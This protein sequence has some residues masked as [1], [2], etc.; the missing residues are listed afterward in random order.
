LAS[1]SASLIENLNGFEPFFCHIVN[2]YGRREAESCGLSDRAAGARVRRTGKAEAYRCYAGLVEIAVPVICDGEHIAT[3]L[4]GQVLPEPPSA[5]GFSQIRQS[6]AHLTYMDWRKL[7]EAYWQTP[8]AEPEDIERTMRVLEVFAEHLATN[9]KRLSNA[10][11]DEQ[12]KSAEMQLCR[13]EFAHMVFDGTGGDPAM[14]RELMTRTGFDRYPNRVLVVRLEL[15]QEYHTPASPF[16]L[17]L[18]RVLHAVEELCAG[19]PN[20]T[21]AYLRDR[22]ICV[23]LSDYEERNGR[24]SGFKAKSLAHRVLRTIAALT[25]IRV[26]IGIGAAKTDWHCLLDSFHEACMALAH[27]NEPVAAYKPPSTAIEELSS[28]VNELCHLVA[29]RRLLDAK[30][31]LVSIPLRANREIGSRIDDLAAQRHFFSY[32]LDSLT[33]AA[34][35]LAALPEAATQRNPNDTLALA[36]SVFELHEAFQRSAES[37]LDEV[38]RLHAG[39]REKLVERACRKIDAELANPVT[40][41]HI[42]VTRIAAGL[43]ISAGHLTRSFKRCT[44]ITFE[45]QL[46]IRRVELA[47]KMLLEPFNNVSAVA[48]RCGFSYPAYFARVFR[49]ITGCSPSEYRENP[50]RL[51]AENH[52]PVTPGAR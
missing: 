47:K 19:L 42:S 31:L 16:E 13:K 24:L 25:D 49:Q 4:A 39:N 29:G 38:R 8:V 44:G 41:H 6:L 23:F 45:R 30:R 26:R 11:K 40:A 20:V 35:Q 33:Y 43:G 32:A 17:A 22:G 27:S 52:R 14:L 15:E 46:M 9:W 48:E 10:V 50:M 5:A 37:I 3:L 51:A 18:T 12:R 2:D 1:P 34:Q 7:G 28:A 36:T 21:C